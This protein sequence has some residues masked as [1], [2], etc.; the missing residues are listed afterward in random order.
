MRKDTRAFNLELVKRYERWLIVQRYAVQTRYHYG[1]CI[2]KFVAFCGSRGVLRTNHFDVQEF[3]AASA[4]KGASAKAIR[5][6]LYALRVFF[7]FLNLGGLLK[8]VPRLPGAPACL[9]RGR[10]GW[11]GAWPQPAPGRARRAPA[12][13]CPTPTRR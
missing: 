4:A 3:L 10:C 6:E 12:W 7:D 2:H 9:E 13:T 11:F 5:G 8:W 1:R